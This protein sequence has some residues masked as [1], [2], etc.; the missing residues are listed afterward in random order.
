MNHFNDRARDWDDAEKIERAEVF[1][2]AIRERVRFDRPVRVLDLGCGTG[3][4]AFQFRDVASAILGVDSSEGMLDVFR[5][6]ARSV[7]GAE[8]LFLDLEKGELRVP[9]IDLVVSSL[10]FHHFPDPV[11]VLRKLRGALAPGGRIAVV[12]LD[13]ED[14]SFHKD[15]AKMGVHH[16]GFS[17]SDARAWAEGAGLEL[18]S[19]DLIFEIRKNGREYPVFLAV[20]A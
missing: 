5:E 10:A 3:L 15:P 17:E 20:F 6:K 18:V 9:P 12:D 14:G 1:G 4:L 2:R 11:A 13:K 16:S 7:P 8:A 19:R